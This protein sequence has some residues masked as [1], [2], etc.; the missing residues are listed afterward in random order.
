MTSRDFLFL[1]PVAA[2][3][4]FNYGEGE[5]HYGELRGPVDSGE[6]AMV[7]HGGFWRNAFDV[8]HMGRLCA[9][10]AEEGIATFNVEY[11]RIGDEGGGWPGTFEDV[12]AAAEFARTLAPRVAVIGYSAG[13][14]LALRLAAEFSWLTGVVG[15]APVADLQRALELQLS[16][17][18]VAEFLGDRRDALRAAS[19]IEN[20]PLS[21]VHIVH[22][23][24]DDI[25]PLELSRNYQLRQPCSLREVEDANHFDMVN[26][27]ST[28]WDYILES[29]VQALRPGLAADSTGAHN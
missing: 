12:R 15:L 3:R 26:P 20:P 17:S 5:F 4:R 19:P 2:D 28:A 25:V 29:I 13:G 22:G 11:R 1:P 18:V 6:I 9:R 23:S 27:A 8:T 14:H 16:N 24:A 7:I 21:Q 10:L